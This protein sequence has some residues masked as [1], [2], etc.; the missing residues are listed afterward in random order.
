[1][2][3]KK[4]LTV[5]A[6]RGAEC[7][8]YPNVPAKRTYQEAIDPQNAIPPTRVTSAEGVTTYYYE[9]LEP[10]VYHFGAAKEGYCSM[11]QNIWFTAEKAQNGMRMDM[12]LTPLA[13][14][15]YEA[16]YLMLY[17]QEFIDAHMRS[18][19][20][21]W[22]EAYRGLFNTPQF[23]RPEGRPGRHQQTTNEEM[24]AFLT[25]LAEKN[26]H[27]HLYSLGKSP[28]YGYDMPLV[29]FTHENVE[30][31][32]L[33]QAAQVIRGNGKPTVQ[34]NAQCH[35]SEPAS[36]EGALAMAL[37]LCGDYGK[38]VL[39]KVDVYIIPRI[40]LDGA[41]HA[42]RTSPTTGE[43]MNRDYMRQNNW[44]TRTVVSVYNLFLP[45]VAIDGHEQF[46]KVQSAGESTCPDISLQTGAGSL[47]HPKEMTAL[48]LK[49]ALKALENIKSVDL[50]GHFY[51]FLATAAGGVAG[52]SYVGTRNSLSFL[53]ETPGQVHA[54]MSFMERRVLAHYV[55]ASTLISFT[56]ENA[57]LVLD[58]V[59]SSRALMAAKGGIYD[60]ADKV[61][62]HHE[63]QETGYWTMPLVHIPSGEVIDAEHK[64]PYT[65]HMIAARTRVRPT[66]YLMP[67]GLEAEEQIL[68]LA[69]RHDI[70]WYTLEPG[71]TVLVRR[72][73][74]VEGEVSLTEEYSHCFESGALVFPNT[75]PSTVLSVYM[76]PDFDRE[77]GRKFGP[78]SIG[79]VAAD[80][81]GDLPVFRYCH[82]LQDGKVEVR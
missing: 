34:Y 3:L 29:L 18:H 70:G 30:G 82:D 4:G 47:N 78:V 56:A 32:T 1:M 9:D 12:R 42:C 50:R 14:N 37:Q 40:N 43:D 74:D 10:G 79:F 23:L 81:N 5:T 67:R 2:D 62:L 80:E 28:K 71:S 21:A 77:A 31:M 58:T 22:G 73:R 25:D 33:E 49:M 66:A 65:E 27:M 8:L 76:E 35:S 38:A 52:S 24:M 51:S 11:C 15:G 59:H 6:D 41:F 46:N 75:V 60:E 63:K 64:V 16:G 13:G 55:L 61:V 36:T 72:Y 44:E 19:K 53:V 54:G 39:D 20:D 57:Q 45:E 17:T 7:G 68:Q 26:E 48:T 69:A